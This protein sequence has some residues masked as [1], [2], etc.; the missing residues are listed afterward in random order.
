MILEVLCNLKRNG[1]GTSDCP[2]ILNSE[3]PKE[4]T[5]DHTYLLSILNS[6]QGKYCSF[7]IPGWM[8]RS[9]L[10]NSLLIVIRRCTFMCLRITVPQA[11][12]VWQPR[13]GTF[14][15]GKE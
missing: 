10:T 9:S 11:R 4:G 2:Q 1:A 12:A 14:S 3:R 7:P 5:L 13:L 15:D 6:Y 8:P